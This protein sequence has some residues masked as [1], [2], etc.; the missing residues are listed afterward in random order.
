VTIYLTLSYPVNT[1]Q[2]SQITQYVGKIHLGH[3]CPET[4][5]TQ[6]HETRYLW[7]Q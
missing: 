6:E 2:E 4:W 1:E 3:F 5:A 7:I